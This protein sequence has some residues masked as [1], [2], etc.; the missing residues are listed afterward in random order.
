M[1]IMTP[2]LNMDGAV[3]AGIVAG[4]ACV[5]AFLWY[6]IVYFAITPLRARLSYRRH[7]ALQRAYNLS[8][9]EDGVTTTNP[10][11]TGLTPWSDYREWLEGRNLFL[12]YVSDRL[13]HLVPKRAFPSEDAIANFREQLRARI[14]S[15]PGRIQK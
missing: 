12:L 2:G 4:F 14:A 9:N 1:L 11:V 13:F 8:W 7:K 3:T 10:N 6:G 15:R 5:I